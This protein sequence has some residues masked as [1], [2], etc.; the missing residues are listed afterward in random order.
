M[1]HFIANYKMNG[2]IPENSWPSYKAL[3]SNHFIK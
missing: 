1:E 2:M 3:A